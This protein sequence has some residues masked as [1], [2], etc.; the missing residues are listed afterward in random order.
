MSECG[1]HLGVF[2]RIRL[3]KI[4]IDP[5]ERSAL[6]ARS[7]LHVEASMKRLF[8]DSPD[9]TLRSKLMFAVVALGGVSQVHAVCYVNAAATGHNDGTSWSD[10]L[11]QLEF[12]LVKPLCSEIWVAKGV[13]KPT[14]GTDR[15]ATFDVL[16]GTAVY[17]GF[18]GGEINRSDRNPKTNLTILSGDIDNNDVNVSSDEI[19]YSTDD[20]VG[21]NSAHVITMDG[22]SGTPIDATTRLDGFVITGGDATLEDMPNE[23]EGGGIFCYGYGIGSGC[24]PTLEQLV[25]SG[26]RALGGGGLYIVGGD[27]VVRNPK[28]ANISF[29]GNTAT[30]SGGAILVFDSGVT[31]SNVLFSKNNAGSGGA[32][33]NEGD[34]LSLTNVTIEHN[35]A[36][37]YGGGLVAASGISTLINVTF[38]ANNGKLGG[39]AI[40]NFG[41]LEIHNSIFWDDQ[42]SDGAEVYIDGKSSADFDHSILQNGCPTGGACTN[43]LTADPRLSKIG[44]YGGFTSTSRPDANSPAIDGGDDA[45]CAV[46]DQRGIPR[47]QGPHCDIGAVEWRLADDIIF[48][49]SFE[50]PVLVP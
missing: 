5:L 20:I 19:D 38:T 3:L 7:F 14:L 35:T 46:A 39:G 9:R 24:S 25:I 36:R 37:G 8:K 26:N 49:D 29:E 17:G 22:S 10:A 2:D 18:T 11:T 28:L 13:Y 43:I 1:P 44:N 47:P 50:P 48:K 41:Q 40:Y 4:A 15:T 27:G 12:A 31:I 30:V 33:Y 42:S 23:T 32:I 45:T 21:N 16:P 6:G 34:F